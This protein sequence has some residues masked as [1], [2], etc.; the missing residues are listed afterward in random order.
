MY[1]LLHVIVAIE[2]NVYFALYICLRCHF[3]YKPKLKRKQEIKCN[4]LFLV[5][6]F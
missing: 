5:Y 4:S 6:I 1:T 2:L 3:N